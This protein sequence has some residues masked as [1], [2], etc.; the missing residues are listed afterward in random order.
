MHCLAIM[1]RMHRSVFIIFFSLIWLL[2]RQTKLSVAIRC[3]YFVFV[4]DLWFTMEYTTR[5]QLNIGLLF[6][7]RRKAFPDT[8]TQQHKKAHT[9]QRRMTKKKNTFHS[10][11]LSLLLVRS[12]TLLSNECMCVPTNCD[13]RWH[14]VHCTDNLWIVISPDASPIKVRCLVERFIKLCLSRLSIFMHWFV[15]A[16]YCLLSRTAAPC[17]R[18]RS[19]AYFTPNYKT[20]CKLHKVYVFVVV[21]LLLVRSL[22]LCSLSFYPFYESEISHVAKN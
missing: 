18:H 21:F 11:S 6:M 7:M 19:V 15:C 20:T 8:F 22:N 9:K 1:V 2:C 17:K 5:V 10:H 4:V 16:L 14:H 13:Q 12:L 3:C